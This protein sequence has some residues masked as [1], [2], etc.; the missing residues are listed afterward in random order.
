MYFAFG[1]LNTQPMFDHN[2]KKQKYDKTLTSSV[3]WPVSLS[4]VQ[5]E[6]TPTVQAQ[7]LAFS[8]HFQVV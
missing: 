5:D 7:L 4:G 6:R 3:A 8:W 1:L 2:T